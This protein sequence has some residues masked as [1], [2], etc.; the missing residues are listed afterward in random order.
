MSDDE[1]HARL[2]EIARTALDRTQ[3]KTIKWKTTDDEDTFFYSGLK[4]SLVADYFPRLGAYELRVLN[5]R[6]TAIASIK[7]EPDTFDMSSM[8]GGVD[9][10][11]LRDLHAAARESALDIDGTLAAALD[12]LLDVPPF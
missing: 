10:N 8:D 4:T 3:A 7:L 12:E 11:I 9:Y 1:N 6:G 2:I 5:S